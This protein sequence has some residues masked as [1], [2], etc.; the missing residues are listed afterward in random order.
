MIM[1]LF[2][3]NEPNMMD[4]LLLIS[5]VGFIILGSILLGDTYYRYNK[6]KK[7]KNKN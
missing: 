5:G 3:D 2:G 6:Y 4:G 1:G 7:R